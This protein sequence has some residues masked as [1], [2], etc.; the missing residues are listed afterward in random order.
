MPEIQLFQSEEF[1]E[2]RTFVDG[3]K[4]WFCGTDITPCEPTARV[5]P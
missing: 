2:L 4:V 1:G 5:M 3:D